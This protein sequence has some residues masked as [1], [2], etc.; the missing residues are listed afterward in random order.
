MKF[1]TF[2]TDDVFKPGRLYSLLEQILEGL[3]AKECKRLTPDELARIPSA[4]ATFEPTTYI[5]EIE[6]DTIIKTAN[7]KEITG[8]DLKAITMLMYLKPRSAYCNFAREKQMTSAVAGSIPLP[9]L[10][11]KRFRNIPY[12]TWRKKALEH[13]ISGSKEGIPYIKV[14]STQELFKIDLL[15]GKTLSSTYYDSTEDTVKL[16]LDKNWGLIT[17]SSFMGDKYRPKAPDVRLFR[18]KGLGNYRG[19][20]AS[21]YGSASIGTNK[22]PGTINKEA[23]EIYNRCNTPMRL[24]LAQRWA[25]YGMHRSSD[26]ICDFQDWDNI[27]KNLD[28][29]AGGFTGLAPSDA[30]GVNSGG[31]GVFGL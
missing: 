22:L 27:P 15:L 24:M 20:F 4:Y 5:P 21:I 23:V 9:L 28:N 31:M 3:P 6:D 26:A 7:G 29:M 1:Q 18:E 16:D 12:D 17:L 10:G 2:N 30:G 11:F 25:W 13:I 8:K 19:H 14:K